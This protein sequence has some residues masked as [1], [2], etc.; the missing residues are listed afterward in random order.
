MPPFDIHTLALVGASACACA[1]LTVIAVRA[2]HANLCFVI[3][4][5]PS[6]LLG[7][8]SNCVSFR[9][10]ILS[11]NSRVWR[12]ACCGLCLHDSPFAL[13]AF[14][15]IAASCCRYRLSELTQ[16][17]C[18]T[19]H[20]CFHPMSKEHVHA[21]EGLEQPQACRTGDVSAATC[22]QVAAGELAAATR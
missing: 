15:L 22:L 8:R 17:T 2:F 7:F 16:S 9:V 19:E 20:Q 1:L 14:D 12:N 4:N 3:L 6:H 13:P 5:L 18:T 10:I 21:R 11:T